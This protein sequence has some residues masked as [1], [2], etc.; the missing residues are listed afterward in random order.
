MSRLLST[1]LRMVMAVLLLG[2]PWP[3]RAAS[4]EA[5]LIANSVNVVEGTGGLTLMTFTINIIGVRTKPVSFDYQTADAS[6][7]APADY[8]TRSGTVT[9]MPDQATATVAV[10]VVPDSLPELTE[11]FYLKLSNPVNAVIPQTTL[12]GTILDDDTPLSP[13]LQI[14]DVSVWRGLSGSR[15]L[16]MSV[17]LNQP[18][19]ASVSVR[20]QTSDV[21]AFAGVDYT[22]KDQLITFQPGET[23]KYFDVTIFG[24]SPAGADVLFLAKLSEGTVPITRATGA[25]I[26]KGGAAPIVSITSPVDGTITSSP[27]S[28]TINAAASD[29]DSP[30]TKV[31]F[32]SGDQLIAT[33]LTAPYSYSVS[34]LDPGAYVLTAKA[35][36]SAPRS[37]TSFPITVLVDLPGNAL[38]AVTLTSPQNSATFVAPA[39]IN[40]AA[41]ASD[42][43]GSVTKVE[44]YAGANKIGEDIS[45][46][47]RF[48]WTNVLAG[49]YNLTARAI[50]NG[51][52]VVVSDPVAISVQATAPPATQAPTRPSGVFIP[53]DGPLVIPL[54]NGGHVDAYSSRGRRVKSWDI[55]EGGEL[56]WDGRNEAGN[57]AAAGVYLFVIRGESK[58]KI[59]LIR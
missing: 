20:A 44:F 4:T 17:T 1:S 57:P 37:T 55:P 12:V 21:S 41:T 19:S 38:P 11:S 35:T 48:A 8:H 34:N 42:S 5:F 27:A 28:F 45:S 29:P 3:A 15:T 47:Y 18:R 54:A 39:T 58:F 32:F 30:I 50:D 13:E 53:K 23:L 46:P 56:E 7:T 33:D 24:K 25:A 2:L 16:S 6:A 10:S 59:A 26:L 14:N 51:G 43:D 31:E 36:N 40:L 22:A 49:N 9:V 52:A